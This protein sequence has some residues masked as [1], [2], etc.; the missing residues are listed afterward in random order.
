MKIITLSI[1]ARLWLIRN[2]WEY[3]ARFTRS[4]VTVTQNTGGEYQYTLPDMDA[5]EIASFVCVARGSQH[6]NLSQGHDDRLH[7]A[8][9]RVEERMLHGDSGPSQPSRDF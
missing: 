1:P 6:V 3:F 7:E 4:A 2:H 9:M 5:V 8:E